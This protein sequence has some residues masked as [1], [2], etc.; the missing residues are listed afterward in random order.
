MRCHK[1]SKTETPVDFPSLILAQPKSTFAAQVN[2]EQSP[3]RDPAILGKRASHQENPEAINLYLSPVAG[4]EFG[5][6]QLNSTHSDWR[7]VCTFSSSYHA[8]VSL[9]LGN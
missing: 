4:R 3:R 2:P 9:C 6:K 8:I 1:G 5:L 7:R